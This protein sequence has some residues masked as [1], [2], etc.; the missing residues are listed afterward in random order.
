MRLFIL[1][2]SFVLQ[3][4]GKNPINGKNS[5]NGKRLNKVLKD[6]VKNGRSQKHK[7]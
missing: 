2:L 5:I 1:T 6:K 3:L 4:N 7:I